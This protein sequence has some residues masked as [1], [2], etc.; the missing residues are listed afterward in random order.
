MRT[1]LTSF[2]LAILILPLA[3]VGAEAPDSIAVTGEDLVVTTHAKG[4]QVYECK[5]DITGKLT[6]QFREPIAMLL[7]DDRAVGRHFAGPTWELADGSAVV[8][9]VSSRAPGA[10]ASDIALLK[11]D[12]TSRQGS[13]QLS[14]IATIQRLNTKG[15]VAEGACESAGVLLSVPYTADYKFYKKRT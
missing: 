4:A 1:R 13:G 9:K 7:V 12:V 10:T 5:A 2:I 15:G 6:W 11:L 14:D 3:L 8:A